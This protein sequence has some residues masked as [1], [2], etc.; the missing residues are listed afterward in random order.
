MAAKKE[1]VFNGS[2]SKEEI[3]YQLVKLYLEEAARLGF[4]RKLEFDDVINAYF[5]ALGRLLKSDV[6]LKA[7]S[8]AIKKAEKELKE[9]PE[10]IFPDVD[11]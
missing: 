8:A 2:P 6:E 3:A 10:D 9:E 1:A 5:Y 11:V 4:K 7:V